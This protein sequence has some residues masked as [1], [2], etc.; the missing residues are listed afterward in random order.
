[1][2][3]LFDFVLYFSLVLLNV[4]DLFCFNV[5]LIFAYVS[6]D[7]VIADPDAV[8]VIVVVVVISVVVFGVVFVVVFVVDVFVVVLVF[9]G[10][11]HNVVFVVV[12]VMFVVVSSVN[13]HSGKIVFL[14]L[15]TL[16][17]FSAF[18]DFVSVIL[19]F[20]LFSSAFLPLTHVAV[21][22]TFFLIFPVILP[23]S[24]LVISGVVSLYFVLNVFLQ[25]KIYSFLLTF[26]FFLFFVSY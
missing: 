6:V 7:V 11:V 10:K 15:H 3:I 16:V 22:L 13:N 19:N 4:I 20:N 8:V 23:I 2:F 9:L 24:N 26:S 1:L 12:V 17:I 14:F 21:V 18:L 25:K 5:F